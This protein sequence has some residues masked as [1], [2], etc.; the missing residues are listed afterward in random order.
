[1]VVALCGSDGEGLRRRRR[2]GQASSRLFE[3]PPVLEAAGLAVA[4]TEAA[5]MGLDGLATEEASAALGLAVALAVMS[6]GGAVR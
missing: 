6:A 2:S 3:W 4:V 1:M 5:A